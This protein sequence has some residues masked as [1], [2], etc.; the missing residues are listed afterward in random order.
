[1]PKVICLT[2]GIGSGKTTVSKIFEKE[3]IPVYIADERAKAIMEKPEVI[4][5]VQ[6]IFDESVIENGTLNRKKIRTLVFDNK[7]LL[8]RL[9][10]VVHPAVKKDFKAWLAMQKEASFVIKESAILFEMGLEN[11]CDSII[12]VTAPLEDRI[13]RVMMRDGAR[14]EDV[15]KVVSN[16]LPDKEKEKYSDFIIK[17]TDKNQLKSQ[18]IEIKN[19]ILT[20]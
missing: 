5:Q 1:M 16:Q 9:N 8:D 10:G 19:M 14:R 4:T 12:L 3:G 2:G 18:V 15:Q 20:K 17:N 6:A 13:E 11:Q 7:E